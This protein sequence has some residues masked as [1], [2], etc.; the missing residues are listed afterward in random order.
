MI[1]FHSSLQFS[2]G[3]NTWRKT[4]SAIRVFLLIEKAV[5]VGKGRPREEDRG[6]ELLQQDSGRPEAADQLPL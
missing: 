5:K 2:L 6:E 3:V 4:R 1:L